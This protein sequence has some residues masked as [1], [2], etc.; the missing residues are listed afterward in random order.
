MTNILNCRVVSCRVVSRRATEPLK[1]HSAQPAD[2]A[3]LRIVAD[4]IGAA[5]ARQE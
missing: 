5:L 2:I 1:P 3:Q 4:R